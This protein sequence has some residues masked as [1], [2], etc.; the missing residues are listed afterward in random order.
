MRF[1]LHMT[2][3]IAQYQVRMALKRQFREHCATLKRAMEQSS[4]GR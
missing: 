2:S 4:G 3:D 1:P